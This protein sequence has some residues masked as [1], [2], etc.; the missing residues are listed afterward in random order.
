[1]SKKIAFLFPGQGSQAVGMGHALAEAYPVARATF[2]EA[3]EALGFSL[4]SLCFDGPEEQL[5]LTEFTQ[6]AIF[7]VSVAA[8]RVLAEHGVTPALAAGHSLGEWSANCLAGT[9]SFGDA[10]RAVRNRGRA[11]Q[12]AVPA[13]QGTMAAILA[14]DPESIAAACAEAAATTGQVVAPANDNSPGQIVISGAVRAVELAAELA[15]AKGARKTVM[16]PVSA[17]FHC[18]MMMPAQER[19]AA[20]LATLTLSDPSVPIAANTSARFVTTA[21]AARTALIEQVTG[22]VR[23]RE[24]VALLIA[25]QPDLF[26]EVGPGKVLSGLMRQIDRGQTCLHAEDPESLAKTLAAIN[27]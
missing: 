23:W 26:I 18:A 5:R 11:M 27:G 13:G 3:D 21:T 10:V 2:A 1:M 22:E 25:E 19:V 17:P 16:L 6:P 8:G 24:C 20:E 9:I 7:T 12:E 4:S 14:L 15:K